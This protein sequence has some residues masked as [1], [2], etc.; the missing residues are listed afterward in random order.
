MRMTLRAGASRSRWRPPAGIWSDPGCKTGQPGHPLE[1]WFGFLAV[2][3]QERR[4]MEKIY[5]EPEGRFPTIA[6]DADGVGMGSVRRF[7]PMG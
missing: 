2:G 3:G 5:Q 4:V 1:G 6:V 7:V